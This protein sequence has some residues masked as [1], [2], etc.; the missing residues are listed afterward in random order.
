MTE[1]PFYNWDTV[2]GQSQLP[3]LG[4]FARGHGSFVPGLG[5]IQFVKAGD[6]AHPV[7][8]NIKPPGLGAS[9]DTSSQIGP[10]GYAVSSFIG[11]VLGGALIGFMASGSKRGALIGSAFTAG[12]AGV[13]DAVVLGTQDQGKLAAFLGLV[14]LTGLGSAIYMRTHSK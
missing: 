7:L 8:G 5:Q 9:A 6:G 3:S 11:A 10:T 14:G 1:I 12:L 13:S 2:T 4:K